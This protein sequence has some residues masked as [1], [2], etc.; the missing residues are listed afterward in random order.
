[1][2]ASRHKTRFIQQRLT[3]TQKRMSKHLDGNVSV[4]T[5]NSEKGG[6]YRVKFQSLQRSVYYIDFLFLE[7]QILKEK[8][9]VFVGL[10]VIWYLHPN[11]IDK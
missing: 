10:S 8:Y 1:M 3:R 9:N 4:A 11:F 2:V 7:S 5:I 6:Y